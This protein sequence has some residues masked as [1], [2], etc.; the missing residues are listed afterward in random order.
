MSIN[1]I[2]KLL[3]SEYCDFE[4]MVLVESPFAQT[5]R[6]GRGIRQVHLG[7]TPSKLVLATDVLPPMA[8]SNIKYIPGIDPDIETFELVAVYPVECF[9]LSVFHRRK[10]QC[11][12]AHFCNNR[13]L[14]FELGGFEKR[15]MF[16]NLWCERLQFL[17]PEDPGSSQSETS[18]ATS[19]SNSTIY[20]LSSRK[21]VT[22]EGIKQ[23]WCNFGVEDVKKS[24][25]TDRFLYM[26][27]QF[28]EHWS[29]YRPRMHKPTYSDFLFKRHDRMHKR[30]EKSSRRSSGIELQTGR[31]SVNRFG[32]GVPE[33]CTSGLFLPSFSSILITKNSPTATE[34]SLIKFERINYP[35]TD[36]ISLTEE[37]VRIWEISR[38][39]NPNVYK[40]KRHRR[41]YGILPQPYFLNGLGLWT[42]SS[43]ERCSIQMK[44]VVSQI[45]IQDDLEEP[46]SLLSI[47][48]KQLV[49]SISCEALH[50]NHHIK[51]QDHGN[52]I[53]VKKSMLYFWTP[54]YLHRPRSSRHSYQELLD[55]LKK[56]RESC[57][58]RDSKSKG[59]SC[60]KKGFYHMKNLSF[61]FKNESRRSSLMMHQRYP[62][63]SDSDELYEDSSDDKEIRNVC[64]NESLQDMRDM[65]RLQVALTA[66]DF[67][68]ST[69]ACQL[70]MIDS[71]LFQ[72]IPPTELAILIWQQTSKDAPNISNVLTFAHRISCLI[73]TEVLR[74]ESNKSRARLMSRL[75]NVADKCHKLSNFQSCRSILCGLQSP[76]V[77]RLH[78]SWMYVRKRH[79]TKY[80][81]FE[82]LSRLYRDPRLPAYQQAFFLASKE[83]PYLPYIGD[84]ILKLLD[85]GRN[86]DS[87]QSWSSIS[88]TV[89]SGNSIANKLKSFS[90][91]KKILL[92]LRLLPFDNSRVGTGNS[93]IP[94]RLYD[95]KI[96]R[97][98]KVIEFFNKCQEAARMYQF[99][100]NELAT[101]YLLKARYKDDYA[102]FLNSF[103]VE[104]S[105]YSKYIFK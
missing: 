22:E 17:N 12:K 25:W 39:T 84:L 38:D 73:S 68:S 104:K 31:L 87:I 2:Q 102:N 74:D 93:F 11:L 33:G 101:E 54:D 28:D 97:L 7:L 46:T 37:G 99:R 23:L 1:R 103:A 59:G 62:C 20:L 5:T 88:E 45:K 6:E 81:T 64:G 94:C 14:Y 26:G 61:V 19:T 13:I 27:S 35:I 41:R 72:R 80:E 10:R 44:R 36:Y 43:G 50:L 98:N 47:S 90:L 60:C 96:V 79:A 53:E 40:R 18:V 85:P 89:K 70:T 4:D 71:D 75:I 69:I 76:A 83:H 66:W 91:I 105:D 16:W 21:I 29:N 78:S 52:K 77:Y 92:T 67:D 42:V 15:H 9:N 57:K 95:D 32:T 86:A 63:N 65:L 30:K 51:I 34:V 100:S 58:K 8:E 49:S 82:R 55:H 24:K 3:F 48:K 56:V